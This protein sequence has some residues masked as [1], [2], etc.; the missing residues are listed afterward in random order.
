MTYDVIIIGGGPAG[1][2]AGIYLARAGFKTLIL[3]KE[4]IGGQIASSAVVENYPGF[5]TI[6]GGELASNIYDQLTLS[7]ADLEIEEV[8]NIQDGKL[9][10]VKTDSNE[11]EAKTIIVAT[12][13]KY[14][15]L[16]LDNED[17]YIGSGIHF[18]VSCDGA[19]YKDKTVAVIGGGN[20]AVGN[21]LYLADIAK[22]VYIINIEDRLTCEKTT[23]TKLRSKDN[24]E[25]ILDTEVTQFK[26]NNELE[27]IVIKNKTE[28]KEITLDGLFISIGMDAQTE[29]IN[30][31]LD[32]NAADYIIS[33]NCET[34]KEGIYVAGDCREKEIRQLTTAVAD[35]TTAAILAMKYLRKN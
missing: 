9:K 3:E 33:N 29:I 13:S 4:T 15:T 22:K 25:I 19:F 2:T 18:C 10:K 16:G 6:S 23:E 17:D 20:S 7:G 27:S 24:V 1:M 35:G 31:L 8:I 12:G 30:D 5:S 26:G 28:T 34:K 32:K 21:A 14:R 11:Y